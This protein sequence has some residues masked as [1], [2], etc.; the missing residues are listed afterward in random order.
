M[1]LADGVFD[2]RI[3]SDGTDYLIVMRRLDGFYTQRFDDQGNPLADAI[4]IATAGSVPMILASNGS[5]Y[6]FAISVLGGVQWQMLDR[7]GRP[8]GNPQIVS[9]S[10]IGNDAVAVT[11]DGIYHLI[12]ETEDCVLGQGCS[13]GVADL[14]VA[15]GHAGGPQM[16][17]APSN[18]IGY[19][20]AASSG[21]RF[22]L[23][24]VSA[25]AINE[26]IFDSND[27]AASTVRVLGTTFSAPLVA[28]WDGS[29]YLVTH[30]NASGALGAQRVGA[31]G[32]VIDAVPF[33]IASN[34]AL[35]HALATGGGR[36]GVVWS[37]PS[38]SQVV[39]VY[40]RIVF[41]FNELAATSAPPLR[42]SNAPPVQHS[43][44]AA[45][46]EG[47][48]I[49][50]WRG[51]DG[52]GSIEMAV[53]GGGTVVL[54][55]ENGDNQHDP[56]I[57]AIGDV[58]LIVWRSDTRPLRRVLGV[59]VDANGKTLDQS[60]IVIDEDT[61]M[62]V[63]PARDRVSVATDGNNFFVAW[64]GFYVVDAKR[65]AKDGSLLDA[66][67]I[68]ATHSDFFLTS[69]VKAVW[70]GATYVV[71]Y[72]FEDNPLLLRPTFQ[73]VRLYAARVSS[74]G[75]ALDTDASRA[76]YEEL[77]AALSDFSAAAAGNRVVI[78]FSEVSNLFSFDL[79]TVE[80][81]ADA[82]P[83]P[84]TSQLITQLAYPFTY[85]MPDAAIAARGDTFLVAWTQDGPNGSEVRGQLLDRGDSFVVSQDDSYDVTVS[86]DAN[87]FSFTYARTDPEA[88]DVAQLFTRD[89]VM[90][91]ARHRA[92]AH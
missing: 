32:E 5:S 11:S 75:V 53:D 36:V 83:I 65:V 81:S 31:D 86:P 8:A 4:K 56:D 30:S 68:V 59:R 33:V 7:L 39:D 78:A 67:P 80:I 22:L 27:I 60:P 26:Q 43:P 40:G 61:S 16:L 64:S 10:D 25:N 79:R 73:V 34:A 23:T 91:P 20:A 41:D 50:V 85:G 55:P 49:R 92:A 51:G 63:P 88:D 90:T 38:A 69:G 46:L 57:A 6:L 71:V 9:G 77:G 3:A 12:Y 42:L 72:A 19:I 87:G 14:A 48:T 45:S 1:K 21:N 62:V 29:R 52:N 17:V 84:L 2:A 66:S 44:A 74:S 82:P 76:V 13:F 70:N 37:A 24:W 15:N 35:L 89:L 18:F 28:G 54:S 58:A 47:R